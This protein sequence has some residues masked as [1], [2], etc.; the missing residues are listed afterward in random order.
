MHN[1]LRKSNF[2]HLISASSSGYKA[3]ERLCAAKNKAVEA[4]GEFLVKSFAATRL[5]ED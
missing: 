1:K 4:G 2:G 3:R 5:K